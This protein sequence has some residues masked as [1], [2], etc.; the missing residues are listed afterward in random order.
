MLLRLLRLLLLRVTFTLLF[1]SSSLSFPHIEQSSRAWLIHYGSYLSGSCFLGLMII[2]LYLTSSWAHVRSRSIHA[3]IDYVIIE[4]VDM[5][6]NIS[7]IQY[8]LYNIQ[9]LCAHDPPYF[10]H[11]RLSVIFI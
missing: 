3:C 1:F 10:D 7:T 11:F 9:L 5:L 6:F 4:P 2:W 8:Q